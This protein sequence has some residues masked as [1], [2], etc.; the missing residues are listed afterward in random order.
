MDIRAACVAIH[1]RADANN[2]VTTTSMTR[3]PA[4][5]ETIHM[6]HMLRM[7]AC[8][9]QIEDLAHVASTDCLPESHKIVGQI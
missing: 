4:H 6:M 5:K 9:G 8:S 3:L 7:E 2:L 1:T